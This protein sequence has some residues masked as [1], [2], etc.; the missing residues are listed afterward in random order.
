MIDLGLSGANF[1]N[2]KNA[3]VNSHDT[4]TSV[5][6]MD[7]EHNFVADLVNSNT[8][9]F[10]DGIVNIDSTQKISRQL[11]MTLLDPGKA[12][13]Q[14]T[15]TPTD[16]TLWADRMIGVSLDTYVPEMAAW[17]QCPIFTGPITHVQPDGF[18][19]NI[20]AQGKEIFLQ[21]PTMYWHTYSFPR[22]KKI[23]AIMHELLLNSGEDGAHIDLPV[24][25]RRT[26]HPFSM[27]GV[28]PV[29]PILNQLCSEIDQ[30][31]F[32]DGDGVLRV[33]SFPTT[34][35]YT[36]NYGLDL[37]TV[38]QMPFDYLGIR[39]ATQVR[40]KIPESG[41]R[42]IA[43]KFANTG[44]I[45]PTRMGRNGQKR[46]LVEIVEDDAISKKTDAQTKATSML[47]RANIEKAELSFETLPIPFLEEMDRVTVQTDT[48][49]FNFRMQQWSIPLTAAGGTMSIG[50]HKNYRFGYRRKHH[51]KQKVHRQPFGPKNIPMMGSHRI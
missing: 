2:Y 31:L 40:G 9:M 33:R 44:H 18:V 39:N 21:P 23:V 15:D 10:I 22:R 38:P 32:Y 51:K 27:L 16:D 12:A 43:T 26:H 13:T 1:N 28:W 34:S 29:W 41:R 30:Q 42:P 48:Q 46:Y 7:L 19:V 5:T 17:V 36:F 49:N 20:E 14:A 4:R 6:L 24:I 11:Q 8:M 45:S 47:T 50:F 25:D 3:L 35:L 37:M